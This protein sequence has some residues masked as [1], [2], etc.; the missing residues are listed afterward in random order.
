MKVRALRPDARFGADLIAGFPTETDGMFGNTMRLVEEAGLS[1]LHVFPFSSRQGTPAARMPQVARA[2]VKARAA[3]LRNKGAE[4]LAQ[5]LAALVGT[6]QTI[7]VEKPGFGRTPCFAPVQFE[8][9]AAPGSFLAVQVAAAAADHL[10][11]VP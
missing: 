10:I 5:T 4:K 7:L 2:T 8:A 6:A 11:G 9:D 1:L 3:Q